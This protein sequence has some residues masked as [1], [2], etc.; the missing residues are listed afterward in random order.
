MSNIPFVFIGHFWTACEAALLFSLGGLLAWPAVRVGPR[1]LVL[2]PMLLFQGVLG[3]FGKNPGMMR[4]FG[5]I[6]GFNAS[7]IFLYMASGFRPWLP[8][9]IAVLTGFNITVIMLLGGQGIEFTAE[10]GDA[11]GAWVPGTFLT[12]LCGLAVLALELPCFCFSIGM[13]VSLGREI[14]E[15]QVRYG[16]G[17]VP[18]A[19][20][21]VLVILPLLLV[22]AVCE[23]IVIR[24]MRTQE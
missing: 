11:G 24:G 8:E 19:E 16:Q 9:V 6:F 7:A 14:L 23:G 1:F 4:M 3:L 18:R 17:I 15:G 10:G 5:V 12:A 20:A 21:Y 2:F 13:G 22:S